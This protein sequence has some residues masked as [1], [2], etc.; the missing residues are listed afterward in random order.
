MGRNK[1]ALLI[2]GLLTI[3]SIHLSAQDKKSKPN[4]KKPVAVPQQDIVIDSNTEIRNFLFPEF[5]YYWPVDKGDT[6]LRFDCYDADNK[7]MNADTISDIGNVAVISFMKVYSDFTQTFI[8]HEGKPKPLPVYRTIY[9][10]ERTGPDTWKAIDYTGNYI[11]ELK[12]LKNV[13]VRSDSTMVTNNVTGSKELTIRK[14]YKVLE[15]SAQVGGVV[16][17]LEIGSTLT[18]DTI[19]YTVP[20]FYFPVPKKNGDTTFE[21]LCYDYRDSLLPN[22]M[23]YDSVKYYSLFKSFIDSNSTYK[24]SNGQKQLLPVSSIMKRYDRIGKEKW[25]C[26]EYPGNKYTELVEYKSI[27]VNLL[28]E[29]PTAPLDNHSTQRIYRFYKVAK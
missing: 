28:V 7:G 27:I 9:R 17:I 2:I 8:D 5:Y 4:T 19:F 13:I 18:T 20:E 16:P 21:F 10:Y 29:L 11:A 26:I 6:V 3:W 23:N 15:T 24:D 25:M 1:A 22:V 12:E 14:Y